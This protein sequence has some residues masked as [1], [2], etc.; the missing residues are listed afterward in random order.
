[1]WANGYITEKV[2]ITSVE[3]VHPYRTVGKEGSLKGW[4][5]IAGTRLLSRWP[6]YLVQA[7]QE[8]AS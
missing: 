8:A 2:E 3:R 1:M 5:L 4:G 6:I 7:W